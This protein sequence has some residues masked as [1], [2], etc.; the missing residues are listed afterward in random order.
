MGTYKNCALAGGNFLQ[1]EMGLAFC[2]CFA[3]YVCGCGQRIVQTSFKTNT[4]ISAGSVY[5][6]ATVDVRSVHFLL[7]L[8]GF[9]L[10]FARFGWN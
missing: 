7:F 8:E 3:R 9:W 4:T 5:T 2:C 1:R 6:G 10:L